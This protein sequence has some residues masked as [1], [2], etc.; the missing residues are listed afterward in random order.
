MA[1]P[2]ARRPGLDGIT[3][4][5]AA[6]LKVA[7]L[8]GLASAGGAFAYAIFFILKALMLGDE[9]HGFPTLIVSMLFLGG[10]QLLCMGMLGEYVARIFTETKGRPIYLIDVHEPA[11]A[12]APLSKSR[13]GA[14]R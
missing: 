11:M 7:T 4:F 2:Q 12:A 9:V 3:A 5:S 8:L 10:L 14:V 13:S 6:P 1:V